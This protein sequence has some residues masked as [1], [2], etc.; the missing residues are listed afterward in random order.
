MADLAASIQKARKAG[1]S[2]ADIAAYLSKDP[3]MSAKVAQAR[4]AGYS[5][6]EIVAH[7]G[8]VNTGRDV[9]LSAASGAG[10]GAGGVAD[11]AMQ[12]SPVGLM[13]ST[14]K[15][16]GMMDDVRRGKTPTVAPPYSGFTSTMTKAGHHPETTAGEYARTFGQMLPNLAAPGG[17]VRR[18]VN[19]FLPALASETAG[20]VARASGAS[21]TGETVARAAGGLAGAGAAS[22]RPPTMRAAATPVQ[23]FGERARVDPAQMRARAGEMR[24]AGVQPTMADVVDDSGRGM[25]RAAANRPTPAR[26][27]A[28]DFSRN[29]TMN[30]PDR[31]STQARRTVSADPRTPDQIRTE[32]AAQRR[33]NADAAFGAVR[34]DSVQLAPEG[35]E[36]LRTDYGRAAIR[37]AA[38]RERDPTT[39]AALNRLAEDAL[40]NPSTP[41]TVGMADRV[42]R[43]L[44]GQAQEAARRGDNDLS[45]TLGGLG[46]SVRGP[47]A[48]ASPGYADAL[49]G[50]GADTRLQEAAGVGEDLMRR[51]TDEFVDAAGRLSPEERP[52]ALAAARRAVERAAGENPSSAPGVARRLADAPE[53]QA[54]NAALMGPQANH[55]QNAM[56]EEARAVENAQAVAPRTGSSTFLNAADDGNLR[57]A[58]GA[59]GDLLRG[60]FG[61]LGLRV[62]D[63]WRT[64]G[65][66]DAQIEELVRTA[67]D[68]AQTDAAI[69]AIAARLNPAQRQEFLSLRNAANV[70]AIGLATG[71][72]STTPAQ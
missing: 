62:Y 43:V 72:A 59:V 46:R 12:M 14:F 6:A 24:A 66:N 11:V 10:Q 20:Q 34:G 21:P 67:I 31:M 37:E 69:N 35:V 58:A 41:V 65:M 50:Y 57:Q 32:M 44:L 1:Y 68:P 23:T 33:T 47:T 40:D 8:K 48:G 45:T 53:Q 55:F 38:R 28:N 52:L 17:V 18:A 16:L 27:A 51:N 22:V 60:R 56:R 3:S 4:E 39:R 9:A 64:R 63:A 61:A 30:M 5:D 29:R 70:G 13:D 2:E 25:I 36:A 54:R 49:E 7:L 19:W 71:A 26:Q 15:T 42:S